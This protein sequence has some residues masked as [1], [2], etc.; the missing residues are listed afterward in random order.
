MTPTNG[1]CRVQN[2]DCGG[3]DGLG[4]ALWL[5]PGWA[6]RA[7]QLRPGCLL[8]WHLASDAL[9]RLLTTFPICVFKDLL[10]WSGAI[11]EPAENAKPLDTPIAMP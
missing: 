4:L 3:L 2:A 1:K 8:W 7:L 9:T 10:K 11:L 6:T 5:R